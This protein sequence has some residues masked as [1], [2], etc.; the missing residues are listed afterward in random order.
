MV[1][2]G[3]V[4]QGL[5]LAHQSMPISNAEGALSH[6]L[7]DSDHLLA[8]RPPQIVLP[9]P[10]SSKTHYS[11]TGQAPATKMVF[12]AGKWWEKQEDGSVAPDIA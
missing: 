1:A 10:P 12:S 5:P 8:L 9:L 3:E 2:G 4:E 11:L 6:L 7:A